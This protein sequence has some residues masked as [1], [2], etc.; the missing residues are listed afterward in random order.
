MR[1]CRLR[2]LLLLRNHHNA[3]I[4]IRMLEVILSAN[5]IARKLRIA[6]ERLIFLADM[7]RRA[8]D[9]DIRTI[10]VKRALRKILPLIP[11]AIAIAVVIAAMM[12]VIILFH[13]SKANPL[14]NAFQVELSGE[15]DS[16]LHKFARASLP[17]RISP[18]RGWLDPRQS[19]PAARPLL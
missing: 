5:A 4:M 7:R 16:Y 14:S 8:P 6:R 17:A 1:R 18:K 19:Q 11:I 10:A 12:A 15:S 13:N 9:L 2:H 3:I